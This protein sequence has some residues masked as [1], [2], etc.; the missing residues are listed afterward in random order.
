MF[1]IVI[2]F[3]WTGCVAVMADKMS[4]VLQALYVHCTMNST[5]FGSWMIYA[6]I[7][8][9]VMVGRQSVQHC[10]GFYFDFANICFFS[11]CVFCIASLYCKTT[12]VVTSSVMV[13]GWVP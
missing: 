10:W 2:G 9:Y 12:T 7:N 6:V 3:D 11:R 13:G 8:V 5:A 1:A 4:A